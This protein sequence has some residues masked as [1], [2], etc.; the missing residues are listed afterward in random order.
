L[1]QVLPHFVET[2]AS[3]FVLGVA[4][5][6]SQR[7]EVVVAVDE[8]RTIKVGRSG[9]IRGANEGVQRQSR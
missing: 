5:A 8:Y 3:G 1:R 9:S 7:G 4:T 2:Q 6:R